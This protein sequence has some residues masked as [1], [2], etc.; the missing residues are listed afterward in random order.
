MS[1]FS[2]PMTPELEQFVEAEIK[3]GNASSKAEIVRRALKS[4]QEQLVVE[5]LLRSEQEAKDGKLL[6]G[7]LDKLAKKI[8]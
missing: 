3:S 7:D 6:R 8:S 5:G 2:I 4:Y 1:T